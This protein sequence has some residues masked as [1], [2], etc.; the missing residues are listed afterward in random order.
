MGRR[1]C[2]TARLGLTP[3]RVCQRTGRVAQMKLAGTVLTEPNDDLW[4]IGPEKRTDLCGDL[5]RM[6]DTQPLQSL[7][8]EDPII[9][10]P[11]GAIVSVNTLPLTK[12]L[13]THKDSPFPRAASRRNMNRWKKVGDY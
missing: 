4:G 7:E 5:H 2:E 3:G 12:H 6:V 10:L 8:I 9:K 13:F 11:F 1:V